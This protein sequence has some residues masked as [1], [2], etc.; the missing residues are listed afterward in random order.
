MLDF[1]PD[2]DTTSSH[3]YKVYFDPTITKT[4]VPTPGLYVPSLILPQLEIQQLELLIIKYFSWLCTSG[5][6]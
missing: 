1:T 3:E 4:V 2:Y 5:L 6:S